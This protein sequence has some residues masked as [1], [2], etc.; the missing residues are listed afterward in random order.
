MARH[1]EPIPEPIGLRPATSI[2]LDC[3]HSSG[4]QE[5][6]TTALVT[7]A[8][9]GIGLELARKLTARR[10]QVIATCREPSPELSSLDLLVESGV[11]MHNLESISS[12][13][14]RLRGTPIDI[15]I[16]N[17]GV[18]VAD[19]FESLDLQDLRLQFEVNAL[20][21]LMLTRHL[22]SNLGRGSKV[23]IITSLMGSIA[24]NGSGG[25][26][27]YRMS[28]AAVNMAGVSLAR[29]LKAT[30]V[31]VLLVHPGYV[32]TRMTG[33]NGTTEPSDSAKGILEQIDRLTLETSGR[34]VRMN[35]DE[36]PW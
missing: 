30:G 7:G 3:R 17:A 36:L 22:R 1:C 28:K 31:S 8:S 21:P 11:E 35:G 34:F 14:E 10:T 25:F 2:T 32:R 23:I 27:G 19:D 16:H 24:D 6:M 13:G 18:L 5:I 4:R 26:Y 33:Y 15:L 20:G 12:L 29:D 9:R